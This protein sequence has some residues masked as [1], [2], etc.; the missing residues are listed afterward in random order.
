MIYGG[1]G[2][3][4]LLAPS[5]RR[6]A[7]GIALVA[8]AVFIALAVHYAGQRLPGSFDRSVDTWLIRHTRAHNRAVRR[9]ANIGSDAGGTVLS[10]AMFGFA[11]WLRRPRAAVLAVL[12]PLV[13]TVLTEYALKP[14]V[15]RDYFGLSYSFP[16]GH[17]VVICTVA[18]TFVLTVLER[19]PARP[20]LSWRARRTAAAVAVVIGAVAVVA[21]VAAPL[22]YATRRRGWTVRRR[23]HGDRRL[24]RHRRRRRRAH[25][26]ARGPGRLAALAS[27][28]WRRRELG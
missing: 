4:P 23:R 8:S 28:R 20:E 16:S 11:L 25:P 7:G 17:T 2:P 22:H 26:P 18:F 27:G 10:L 9:I 19:R 12:A 1:P 5:R 24:G 13:G 15:G 21:V 14:L 3:A 6:A